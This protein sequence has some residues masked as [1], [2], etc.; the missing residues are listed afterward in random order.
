[1]EQDTKVKKCKHY[2]YTGKSG[3]IKTV[4]EIRS[5]IK[6]GSFF[7]KWLLSVW[8]TPGSFAVRHFSNGFE[9]CEKL[10]KSPIYVQ[11]MYFRYK[12][13]IDM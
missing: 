6:R 1:M 5:I 8:G 7:K 4:T 3:T 10:M 9:G 2:N 13:L 12:K 11:N